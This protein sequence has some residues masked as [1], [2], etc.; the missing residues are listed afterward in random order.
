[1]SMRFQSSRRVMAWWRAG[2]SSTQMASGRTISTVRRTSSTL[3]RETW[4]VPTMKKR[5]SPSST[6][7]TLSGKFSKSTK[8]LTGR[9]LFA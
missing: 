6:T 2:Q 9:A 3:S 5:L 4:A 8:Y 1:M 7:V